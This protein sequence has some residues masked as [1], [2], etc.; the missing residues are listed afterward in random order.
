MRRQSNTQT[1]GEAMQDFFEK[2]SVF[3]EKVLNARA[4][5][6]WGEVL[7]PTVQQYTRN[8]WVK[9]RVLYVSLTSSVLRNELNLSKAQIV[10]KLN[11]HVG[12]DVLDDIV[13]R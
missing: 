6:A 11:Q 1:L 9:K 2:N 3:R 8:A 12:E 13:L 10:H 7:G 4:E 5:L